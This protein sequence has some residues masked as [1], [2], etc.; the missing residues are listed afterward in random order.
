[1]AAVGLVSCVSRKRPQAAEA[2]DLYESS[3]F[4]KARAFVERRCGSRW[5]ILSAKYGLLEPCRIIE[6]YDETLNA[7]SRSGRERWAAKVWVQLRPH[8]CGGDSVLVL[9]GQRYRE[10]LTGRLIEH[11]CKVDVPMEGLGIGCQL[12]WLSQHTKECAK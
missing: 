2:K 1:M 12:H 5:Y 4:K 3:L 11:G 10:F 7:M 9:A 6:P 8:L